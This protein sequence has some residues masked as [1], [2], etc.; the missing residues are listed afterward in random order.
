[1]KPSAVIITVLIV[2]FA[3]LA[4]FAKIDTITALFQSGFTERQR[5][6]VEQEIR[7]YYVKG[8]SNSPSVIERTE[9]NTGSTSIDVHMVKVS[10]KRLEGFVKL[11]L[12]DQTSR[13]LGLSD[14]TV[15]CEATLGVDPNQYVW[16]CQSGAP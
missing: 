9:F 10:N 13:S 12:H 5:R 16:K 14:V 11:S 15:P 7:A 4:Y 3:L 6:N 1:M 2:G 8:I